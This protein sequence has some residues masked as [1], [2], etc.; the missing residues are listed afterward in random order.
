[1]RWV[2]PQWINLNL[3]Y[4]DLWVTSHKQINLYQNEFV[5][6]LF[7][8]VWK[9]QYIWLILKTDPQEILN[10]LISIQSLDE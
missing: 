6:I 10:H 1:M 9:I 2:K 5:V 7:L 8:I 4:T 3:K